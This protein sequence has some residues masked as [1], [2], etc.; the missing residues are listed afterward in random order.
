MHQTSISEYA[1]NAHAGMDRLCD[2]IKH[3]IIDCTFHHIK[4]IG[5]GIE[6]ELWKSTM[7]HKQFLAT[8][9][10]K[11]QKFKNN[12]VNT[13]KLSPFEFY[14]GLEKREQ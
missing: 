13:P 5:L 4:G 7:T 11:F 2:S 12:V 3:N 10:R 9:P 8:L 1:H 6:A 14:S